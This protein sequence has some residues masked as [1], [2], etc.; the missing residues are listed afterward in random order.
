MTNICIR[1]LLNLIPVQKTSL[2]CPNARRLHREKSDYLLIMITIKARFSV[3]IFMASNQINILPDCRVIVG[4]PISYRM[5]LMWKIST[6]NG[7]DIRTR[8][9]NMVE[10]DLIKQSKRWRIMVP[11]S[12]KG[13]PLDSLCSLTP[14]SFIMRCVNFCHDLSLLIIIFYFRININYQTFAAV[15]AESCGPSHCWGLPCSQESYLEEHLL[16]LLSLRLFSSSLFLD[17]RI[18]TCLL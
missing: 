15:P 14:E 18:L 9:L 2:C 6:S 12:T 8:A 11:T 13:R 3:A 10:L 5:S 1:T 17:C 4:Q 16:C 7:S